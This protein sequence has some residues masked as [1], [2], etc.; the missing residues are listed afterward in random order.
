MV[1]SHAAFSLR[2]SPRQGHGGRGGNG[3]ASRAAVV[4]LAREPRAA[5]F[6]RAMKSNARFST[7]HPSRQKMFVLQSVILV[8]LTSVLCPHNQHSTTRVRFP[9]PLV[10]SSPLK[11]AETGRQLTPCNHVVPTPCEPFRQRHPKA[12][13]KSGLATSPLLLCPIYEILKATRCARIRGICMQTANSRSHRLRPRRLSSREVVRTWNLPT[14]HRL[15]RS[16]CRW[17]QCT[18]RPDS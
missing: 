11:S 18:F 5:S 12:T 17:Q 13:D 16:V 8:V 2:R 1:P 7:F 9:R 6:L 15:K 3:L 10:P 14:P 4:S